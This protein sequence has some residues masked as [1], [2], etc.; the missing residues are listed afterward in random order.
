MDKQVI[1]ECMKASFADTP[2]PEVVARLA[3]AGV[4]AYRA[5]LIKLRKTY[6]D[7]AREAYDHAMPYGEAP[8]VAAQFSAGDV[9]GA[10]SAIQ[11]REIG[12]AEFL[13]RIMQAGCASYGVYIGGRKAVYVGRDGDE[14]VEPFPAKP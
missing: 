2:F 4:R 11:R 7:D 14:Y 12:Y 10:V 9:A 6:Y 13:K 3:G 5:D 1:A 8:D